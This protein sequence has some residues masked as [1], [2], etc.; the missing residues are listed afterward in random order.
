MVSAA[1]RV[2]LGDS[3]RHVMRLRNL[4]ILG[5]GAMGIN[6][7]FTGFTGYLPTYLK[8]IGWA[9]LDADRALAAFFATSL[10]AVI[11]LSILS[12]R[13]HLRRGYLVV[14]GLILSIGI[15]SLTFVESSMILIVVAAT[16][17]VFDTFMAILNASV[18]EVKGVGYVYAGT[19]LGF[20]ATIR[21][22]GGTFSPPLGNSLAEHIA[23]N[24]PFLFWGGLGLL[25]V[26]MFVF[27]FKPKRD[28]DLAESDDER[29]VPDLSAST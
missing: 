23:P 8:T 7:C 10:M 22:L 27:V 16:G 5:I 25:G 2:S 9:D 19:A 20:A 26:F 14:A 12:D 18:M 3:L 6:A 24:I 1:S 17:L 28:S 15:G 11:P 4:W 13:L 29:S 21:S